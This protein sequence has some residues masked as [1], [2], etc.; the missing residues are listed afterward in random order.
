MR[1][2]WADYGGY[3]LD[4]NASVGLLGTGLLG[5]GSGGGEERSMKTRLRK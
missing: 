5:G 2:G 3:W 1:N 4:R